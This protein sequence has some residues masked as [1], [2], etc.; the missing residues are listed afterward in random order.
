VR[1]AAEAAEALRSEVAALRGATRERLAASEERLAELQARP[2]GCRGHWAMCSMGSRTRPALWAPACPLSVRV[3]ASNSTGSHANGEYVL[4]CERSRDAEARRLEHGHVSRVDVLQGM[5]EQGG[6]VCRGGHAA[7]GTD[8]PA[9]GRRCRPR[10]RRRPAARTRTRSASTAT[11][12]RRWACWWTTSCTCSARWRACTRTCAPW[13]A[14]WPPRAPDARA[15]ALHCL[16]G[17]DLF[18]EQARTWGLTCV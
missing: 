18:A 16:G 7:P 17:P 12:P 6:S 4:V 9:A 5:P 1:A 14:R 11:W 10:R 13:P 3:K 2:R 15:Q 8:A